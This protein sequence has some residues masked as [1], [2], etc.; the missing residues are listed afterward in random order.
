MQSK[1][2]GNQVTNISLTYDEQ[3]EIEKK[4]GNEEFINKFF[5]L[6]ETNIKNFKILVLSDNNNVSALEKL[7][8]T[9]IVI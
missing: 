9:N 2:N 1:A 3:S 7:F 4:I 6:N 5:T 8:I